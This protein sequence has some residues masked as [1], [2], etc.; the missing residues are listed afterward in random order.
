MERSFKWNI[1]TS[2]FQYSMGFLVAKALFIGGER[3]IQCK[4]E[5]TEQ[6]W[7]GDK[8]PLSAEVFISAA[9]A[10]VLNRICL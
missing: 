3:L 5:S 2:G 6:P 4:V 8:V 10:G 7:L 9:P 1:P